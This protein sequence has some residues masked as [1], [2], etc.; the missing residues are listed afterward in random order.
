MGGHCG[1]KE[2]Q[3]HSS[4]SSPRLQLTPLL[5][6]DASTP[7]LVKHTPLGPHLGSLSRTLTPCSR[8]TLASHHLSTRTHTH[9]PAKHTARTHATHTH[10]PSTHPLIAHSDTHAYPA[11][12]YDDGDSAQL[13]AQQPHGRATAKATTDQRHGHGQGH[14]SK[15][16]ARPRQ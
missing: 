11:D 4:P 7:A 16:T 5:A 9:A 8:T 15:A 14:G 10:S 2:S 13:S 12:D 6:S 3:V 1:G